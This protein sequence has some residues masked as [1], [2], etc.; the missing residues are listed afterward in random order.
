MCHMNMHKNFYSYHIL[1]LRFQCSKA[2]I[3][4]PTL[5]IKIYVT[6]HKITHLHTIMTLMSY[7]LIYRLKGKLYKN[8]LNNPLNTNNFMF[9][10]NADKQKHYLDI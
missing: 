8:T 5:S 9:L 1:S 7:W 4:T 2:E 6:S 10:Q 3:Q